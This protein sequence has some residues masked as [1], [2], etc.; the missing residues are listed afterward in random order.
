MHRILNTTLYLTPIYACNILKLSKH[1]HNILYHLFLFMSGFLFDN[2]F[3]SKLYCMRYYL[4]STF[5][6]YAYEFV[7]IKF[8]LQ[9][10]VL[11]NNFLFDSL[12]RSSY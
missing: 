7:L 9:I 6:K 4:F 11:V 10:Y 2:C 8:C 12:L 3:G 1:N 5:N